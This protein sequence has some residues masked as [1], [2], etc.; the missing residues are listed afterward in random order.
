MAIWNARQAGG[1]DLR[2][3]AAIAAGVP[4]LT[5]SCP[6]CQ[7]VGWVDLRTLDTPLQSLPPNRRGPLPSGLCAG[8]LGNAPQGGP[9]GLEEA[10][11]CLAPPCLRSGRDPERGSLLRSL[12]APP[13]EH[14]VRKHLESAWPMRDVPGV[15]GK[16]MTFTVGA[17]ELSNRLLKIHRRPRPDIAAELLSP[18][19]DVSR[20]NRFRAR[21]HAQISG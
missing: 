21:R 15:L 1:R 18:A 2:F 4:W 5:Y 17:D 10:S 7:Q 14:R 13:S 3:Y 9:C 12:R 16:D 20:A 8:G 19:A 11:S 6:A